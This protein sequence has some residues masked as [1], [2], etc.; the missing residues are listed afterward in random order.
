MPRKNSQNRSISDQITAA[1]LQEIN[2]DLDDIYTNGDDI[3]RVSLALSGTP[4]KVDIGAFPYQVHGTYWLYVWTTEL[5]IPDDTTTYVN[6]NNTGTISLD[7]GLDSDKALLAIVVTAGGV[8]TSLVN[9]KASVFGGYAGTGDV[10]GP[11]SSTTDNIVTF[12]GTTGKL[13]KDS[14]IKISTSLNP[15]DTELPTSKAVKE[16]INSFII[17]S[18]YPLGEAITDITKSCVFKESDIT[19]AQATTVQNVGEIAA[20]KRASKPIILNGE[21]IQFMNLALAVSDVL[22]DAVWI[23]IEADDGAWKPNWT[24]IAWLT[25]TLARAT[26]WTTQTDFVVPL[27]DVNA[28]NTGVTYDT[29]ATLTEKTWYKFTTT[30]QKTIKNIIKDTS[31][32]ATTCYILDNAQ[33]IL[34]TK[35]FATNDA[36]FN[37]ILPAGTY[38]VMVDSA[39]ASYTSRSKWL[40]FPITTANLTYNPIINTNVV[41][42][43]QQTLTATSS[44]ATAQWYR[45]Q[46]IFDIDLTKINKSS[47]STA[48]RAIVK[49]DAW[50]VLW[51]ATFVGNVATLSTTISFNAN[52]FFRVELDASWASY[53]RRYDSTPNT[54]PITKTN[55]I[56]NTGSIDWVNNNV[57]VNIDSIE[58]TAK[59]V[60]YNVA[61]IETYADGISTTA[62]TLAHIVIYQGTYG[63]ETVDPARYTKVG[64]STLDTTTR[65]MSL[66]D[67]SRWARDTA[68]W[69]YAPCAWFHSDLLSLTDADF[70]Y[71]VD[72]YGIA[73]AIGDIG[74]YPKLYIDG[75]VPNFT[76][77]TI[78]NIQYLSW[79]LGWIS[80]TGWTNIK[81]IWQTF[82]SKLYLWNYIFGNISEFSTVWPTPVKVLEFTA[83]KNWFYSWSCSVKSSSTSYHA[84]ARVYKNWVYA[85]LS[86]NINSLSYVDY[87]SVSIIKAKKGDLLQVYQFNTEIGQTAYVK[88]VLFYAS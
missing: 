42:D 41:D 18:D 59:N 10:V 50:A 28:N 73:T 51:T 4:L 53:S 16:G 46:A 35:T 14:G 83:P 17:T 7:A 54:F 65:W 31:C 67:S 56:Y 70:S 19:Y 22:W 84:Y 43:D 77:M 11:A 3:G 25:K 9:Y 71:K 36:V 87:D 15:V 20:N 80:N 24:L 30:A 58:T 72:L 1:R 66:F 79:T 57:A 38:Y 81:S 6:V 12:W 8:I 5:S 26:I 63:S 86:E 68:K 34:Y 60:G 37:I 78:W 49:S 2:E 23:R 29:S 48:T 13:V 55:V 47:V 69:M 32:T 27:V 82:N 40:T 44:V 52:E 76:G 85:W 75:V 21:P 33:N 62:G 39:G 45:M 64:Y 88:N 61:N 74:S